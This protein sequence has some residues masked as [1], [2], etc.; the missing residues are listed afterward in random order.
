MWQA[1]ALSLLMFTGGSHFAFIGIISDR[2]AAAPAAI[3]ASSLLGVRNGLYALELTAA[4]GGPRHA[5]GWPRR[6]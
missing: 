4:A 6:T 5:H 1:C 3:A 2:S